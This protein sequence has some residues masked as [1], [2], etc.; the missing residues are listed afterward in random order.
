M[1]ADQYEADTLTLVTTPRARSLRPARLRTATRA[2]A[3]ALVAGL[4]LM[5]SPALA[6]VPSGWPD[7]PDV[8]L[9]RALTIYLFLPVALFVLIALIVMVPSWAR[10]ER[11]GGT[12]EDQWFGGRRGGPDELE[13]GSPERTSGGASGNW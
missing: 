2:A 9:M 12:P 1:H 11:A 5:A 3:V 7:P 13:A 8:P 10:G 6:D 4:V